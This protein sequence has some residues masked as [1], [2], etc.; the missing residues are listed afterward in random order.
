MRKTILSGLRLDPRLV[1]L[2]AIGAMAS[3]HCS[4]MML[5]TAGFRPG[6]VLAPSQKEIELHINTYDDEGGATFA[7]GL[8]H[9][10]ELRAG[11]NYFGYY[12]AHGAVYGAEAS[13]AKSVTRQQLLST[14]LALSVGG[15][16]SET[17]AYPLLAARTSITGALG[18]CPTSWLGIF[19][20]I[21]LSWQYAN[22]AYTGFAL[23][24]GLGI[25]ADYEPFF[26]RALFDYSI[27]ILTTGTFP[28]A[29]F[30]RPSVQLGFQ[31]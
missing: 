31:W 13:L 12:G 6:R 10:L 22:Y 19:A 3:L 2:I 9:G 5:E 27:P 16:I 18:C 7:A 28:S 1:V 30:P 26:F 4:V 25:G 17:T 8:P 21:R 14:S 20:P 23:V 29:G 11:I 15:C 24:P